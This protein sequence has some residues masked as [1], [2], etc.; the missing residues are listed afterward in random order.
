MDKKPG[1]ILFLPHGGGPMPLL[2]DPAHKKLT[3]F[4]KNIPGKL[5]KPDAI[6]VIS[7]HWEERI[8][9]VTGAEY[10]EMIYDYSGF[11][12]ETYKIKY[13]SPGNP[14]LADKIMDI[15][16]KNGISAKKDNTRGYD[17]GLF[18]PLMLMYPDADIP[19][20]QIS[21]KRDLDPQDHINIGKALAELMNENILVVGSGLSFHNMR[22]F[23]YHSDESNQKAVE[24]N[25]WLIDTITNEKFSDT[26]REKKLVN[27]ANAPYAR[28][29]HPREDHLLPLHVC[30]GIA[31]AANFSAELVFNDVAVGKQVSAFL[32]RAF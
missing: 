13:P 10:P 3:A 24:F 32:W 25:N 14:K 21:Q 12:E 18:V 23:F 6:V 5:R 29:A 19:S 28:F 31:S 27:W 15:F 17:H 7:A 11:P 9:T 1:Q 2:G 4:M 26:E 16:S 30:F 8:P 20:I 22:E